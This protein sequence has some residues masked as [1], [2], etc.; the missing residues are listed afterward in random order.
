MPSRHSNNSR[1]TAGQYRASG[2]G[3]EYYLFSHAIKGWTAWICSSD[4]FMA[5]KVVDCTTCG[6]TGFASLASSRRPRIGL[7]VTKPG[8]VGDVVH[9]GMGQFACSERFRATCRK[10]RLK[11]IR[12]VPAA[13]VVSQKSTQSAA[14]TVTTIKKTGLRIAWITGCA[15]PLRN[16]SHKNRIS[17]KVCCELMQ[18]VAARGIVRL[19]TVTPCDADFIRILGYPSTLVSARAVR[20]LSDAGLAH[21]EESAKAVTVL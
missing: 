13:E 7:V 15:V 3:N 14:A 10:A 1:R 9:L 6:N 19:T 16:Q 12:F 20:L 17:P 8:T 4:T 5:Y 2:G 18:Q 21:F 11:G